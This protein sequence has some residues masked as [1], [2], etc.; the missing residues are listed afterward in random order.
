M[1]RHH[2]LS[3]SRAVEAAKLNL[4]HA[5]DGTTLPQSQSPACEKAS[6]A[7]HEQYQLMLT[8]A[9][10]QALDGKRQ[11]TPQFSGAACSLFGTFSQD[12]TD[13][14]EWLAKAYARKLQREGDR[15][16]GCEAPRLTAQF[17]NR[18]N[19]RLQAAI[20]RGT[21]RMLLTAG[22]PARACRKYCGTNIPASRQGQTSGNVLAGRQTCRQVGSQ[23]RTVSREERGMREKEYCTD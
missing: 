11:D 17:R 21:A 13:L 3:L 2:V 9:A 22:L 10:K 6:A 23:S 4:P 12:L 5:L 20:A 8:I 7:K 19:L 14:V 15:D 18:L 16:D 1:G